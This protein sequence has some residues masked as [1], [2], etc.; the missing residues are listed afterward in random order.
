MIICR[1]NLKNKFWYFLII[2]EIWVFI[3]W[4]LFYMRNFFGSLVGWIFFNFF[5]DELC[6]FVCEMFWWCGVDFC[7][8]KILCFCVVVLEFVVVILL[9]VVYDGC[10]SCWFFWKFM[11]ML[12]CI[13]W[14]VVEIMFGE[15]ELYEFVGI[16]VIYVGIWFNWFF[17]GCIDDLYFMFV[18]L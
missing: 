3:I 4:K 7:C 5:G 16:F 9:E 1:V 14:L 2:C 15:V 11:I 12:D 6:L 10:F 13:N 18:E 17:V 8:R